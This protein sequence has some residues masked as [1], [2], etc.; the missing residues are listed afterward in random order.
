MSDHRMDDRATGVRFLGEAKICPLASASRLAMRPTQPPMGNGG[1]FPRDKM[2][3][4][5]DADHI[6]PPSVE[7]KNE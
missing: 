1:P 5:S 6:P 3:P 2:L 4:G 7:V